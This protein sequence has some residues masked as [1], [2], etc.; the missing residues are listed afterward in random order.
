MVKKLIFIKVYK[1]IVISENKLCLGVK[2][3]Q[4]GNFPYNLTLNSVA[5]SDLSILFLWDLAYD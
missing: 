4:D 1:I 2:T 3:C 5:L